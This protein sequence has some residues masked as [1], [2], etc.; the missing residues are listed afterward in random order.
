MLVTLAAMAFLVPLIYAGVESQRFHIRQVQQEINLEIAHRHAES[1]LSMVMLTLARDSLQNSATD[2][3]NEP[4]ASPLVLP[5]N[6]DGTTEAL[7]ED[8]SR[9]WN[10]NALKKTDGQINGELRTVLNA[11]F[12][13]EEV[14]GRLLE[15]LLERLAVTTTHNNE[16]LHA[17]EE[18]LQLP[19]WTTK[20]LQTLQPYITVDDECRTGRLNINT[21]AIKTLEPLAPN[22]NWRSV[23][24]R[25]K[26]TP[27]AQ[28]A[29]LASAGVTLP[30]EAVNLLTVNSTC[31]VAQIRSQVQT[32]AGTLTAWLVRNGM[33]ITIT[34]TRWNG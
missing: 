13:R 27:F 21:A 29:D 24:E 32:V 10:L 20:P 23:E 3:L 34:K 1:M 12:Q 7:I 6:E 15:S 22:L 31:F 17:L 30:L 8:T 28:V 18:I 2:H 16:P 4:W 19:E 26:Q 33:Q 25:R 14:S 9:R 11:L 5:N